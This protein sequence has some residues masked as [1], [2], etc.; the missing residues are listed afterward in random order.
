M[1]NCSVVVQP[2]GARANFLT[3]S[4]RAEPL[5]AM[6]ATPVPSPTTAR[7][8]PASTRPLPFLAAGAA[9][10]GAA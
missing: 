2:A 9:T 3:V 1:S 10:G 5:I 7:P 4:S 8:M 6:S